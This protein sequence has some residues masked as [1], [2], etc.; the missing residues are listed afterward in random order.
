MQ[1]IIILCNAHNPNSESRVE[2]WI[3]KFSKVLYIPSA[4][5][6]GFAHHLSWD[7]RD[8]KSK[9]PKV[10]ASLI[11]ADTSVQDGPS[12]ILFVFYKFLTT[13]ATSLSERQ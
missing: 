1:G 4:Q 11:T 5:C 2:L 3:D 8:K 9:S 13:M 12:T 6:I 7:V 10:A